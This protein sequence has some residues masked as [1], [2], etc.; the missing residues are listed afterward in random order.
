MATKVLINSASPYRVSIN[1]QQ[2]KNIRT[3]GITAQQ[4]TPESILLAGL[5]D[6]DASGAENNETLVYDSSVQKY[7]VKPLPIVDGGTF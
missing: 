3:V 1:N 5:N 2:P 6:V 7:I 4:V